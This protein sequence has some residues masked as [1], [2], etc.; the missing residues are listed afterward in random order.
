LTGRDYL[1]DLGVNGKTILNKKWVDNIKKY[2]K[3]KLSG[4]DSAVSE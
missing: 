1:R 2:I 3:E 4:L